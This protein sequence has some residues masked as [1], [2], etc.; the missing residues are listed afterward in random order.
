M[1]RIL[2]LSNFLSCVIPYFFDLVIEKHL[3]RE[4]INVNEWLKLLQHNQ[5][6]EKNWSGSKSQ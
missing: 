2:I 6:K 1:I 4:R 3:R 5:H